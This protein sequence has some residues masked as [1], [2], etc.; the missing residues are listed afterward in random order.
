MNFDI[1][2]GL[3][4][5]PNEYTKLLFSDGSNRYVALVRRSGT[6]AGPGLFA[7]ATV[8]DWGLHVVT[9]KPEVSG[10]G[11]GYLEIATAK[12]DVVYLRTE[13]R[14][15][16]FPEIDG[17]SDSVFVGTWEVVG[18]A[19]R[20]SGLEGAGTLQVKSVSEF[21]RQ[22]ILTGNVNRLPR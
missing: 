10:K 17:K 5:L 20:F 16:M 13:L 1:K 3:P 14:S 15:M 19:G 9:T 8:Q 18:A 11:S 22:W 12:S 2:N 21:E 7:G 6:V 4:G